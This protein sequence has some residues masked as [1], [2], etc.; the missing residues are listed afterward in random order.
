MPDTFPDVSGPIPCW[1]G[2]AREGVLRLAGLPAGRYQAIVEHRDAATGLF[3]SGGGELRVES[4]AANRG[5]I[6]V[7]TSGR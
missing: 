7:R 6:P 4:G 3:W 2:V 1:G 5:T